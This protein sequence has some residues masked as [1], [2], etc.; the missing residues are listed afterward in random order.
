MPAIY[1]SFKDLTISSKNEKFL[2]AEG[3]FSY[4]QN[5]F[6]KNLE[7]KLLFNSNFKCID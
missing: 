4:T 7:E 5:D 3:I 2:L 1:I 6:F